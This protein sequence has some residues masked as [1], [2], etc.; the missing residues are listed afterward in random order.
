MYLQIDK[1]EDFMKML[2]NDLVNKADELKAE[3]EEGE[4]KDM[5]MFKKAVAKTIPVFLGQISERDQIGR[6]ATYLALQ[7]QYDTNMIVM[8]RE[9]VGVGWIARDDADEYGKVSSTKL[10]TDLD[11]KKTIVKEL[12]IKRGFTNIIPSVWIE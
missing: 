10:K 2:E 4:I 11:S 6:I 5:D 12:L 9:Y 3:A 1:A 7:Y 8:Y